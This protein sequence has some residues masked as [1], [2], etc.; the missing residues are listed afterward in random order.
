M[1]STRTNMMFLLGLA[2]GAA[3]LASARREPPQPELAVRAHGLADAGADPAWRLVGA[4][5]ALFERGDAAAVQS[6]AA[7]DGD[8]AARSAMRLLRDLGLPLVP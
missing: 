5:R 2:L 8:P 6:L 3:A 1:M 7:A 4:A